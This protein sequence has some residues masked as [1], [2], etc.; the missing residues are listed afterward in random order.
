M[1]KWFQILVVLLFLCQLPLTCYA[2]TP[3]IEFTCWVD[4]EKIPENAVYIDLLLPISPSDEN[5]TPYH[6]ENGATF[7]IPAQSQIVQYN[8]DGYRS[9]TFHIQDARSEMQ[10]L[11][12]ASSYISSTQVSFFCYDQNETIRDAAENYYQFCQRYKTAKMAYLDKD[13]GIISITNAV[14]LYKSDLL[15]RNPQTGIRLSGNDLSLEISYGPPVYLIV[16]TPVVLLILLIIGGVTVCIV[17]LRKKKKL[18]RQA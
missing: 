8:A 12:P 10:L 3:S 17:N 13:G 1:K 18:R 9:Y 7:G 16:V 6:A 14:R 5:Y 11:T 15:D 2:W 4:Y